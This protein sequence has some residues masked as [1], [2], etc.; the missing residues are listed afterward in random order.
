MLL[1]WQTDS[2]ETFV[3]TLQLLAELSPQ[4]E[5]LLAVAAWNGDRLGLH[6]QMFSDHPT[7]LQQRYLDNLQKILQAHKQ[8]P[9]PTAPVTRTSGAALPGKVA[10]KPAQRLDRLLN[11]SEDLRTI[12]DEWERGPKPDHPSHLTPDRIDGRIQ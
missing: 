7:A 8:G 2:P 11:E 1:L 5:G 3:F 10:P 9:K 4:E 12:R 6:K